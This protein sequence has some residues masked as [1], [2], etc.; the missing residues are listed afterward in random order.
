[1][2]KRHFNLSQAQLRELEQ[3]EQTCTDVEERRRMQGVRLYGS[4]EPLETVKK[5]VQASERSIR[6][7][8]EGY[9]AAGVVGL[10]RPKM[11][12]NHRTL[13]VEQR[14]AVLTTLREQ[15]PA[16]VGVSECAY[17]SV[18][19]VAALVRSRFGLEYAAP[20]GYHALLREAGLSYQKVAK[21]YRHRPPQTVIADWEADAEKK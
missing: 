8:T 16:S 18:T 20:S 21:V 13:S 14:A 4:G 11:T 12:G 1:M 3:A 19:A 9:R 2:D 7:W 15:T 5:V 6:R 10:A 17:W